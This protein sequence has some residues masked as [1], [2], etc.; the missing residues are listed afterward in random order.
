[1]VESWFVTLTTRLRI[2]KEIW[3]EIVQHNLGIDT[4]ISTMMSDV[5]MTLD[6][7]DIKE[8]S[9]NETKFV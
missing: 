6:F 4:S 7:E 5:W 3:K 9:S 2:L 8:E 1:M